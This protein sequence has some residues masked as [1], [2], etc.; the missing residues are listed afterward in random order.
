MAAVPARR[1]GVTS[2]RT[3]GRCRSKYRCIAVTMPGWGESSPQTVQ[4]GRDGGRSPEAA[5]RRD[6]HRESRICRQFDGRRS[7]GPFYRH[8]SGASLAP[9]HD[10]VGQ[11]GRREH[12]ATGGP[13]RR[14]PHPRGGLPGPFPAQH[15]AARADHVL[16]PL[17][18]VRGAGAAAFGARSQV[19]PSTTRTGSSCCALGRRWRSLRRPWR[20]CR[21]RRCRLC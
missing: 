21:P 6:G 3:S 16:R 19:I 20:S 18:R 5:R 12:A 2:R 15:E 13:V 9:H 10:G 11:P 7:L 4:T 14:H 1:A 8:L 17:A